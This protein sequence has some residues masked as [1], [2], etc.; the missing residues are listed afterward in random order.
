MAVLPPVAP[1]TGTTVTTRLGRDYYVTVGANAYSVHPEAIGRMITVTISLDRVVARCTDRI[2]ADHEGSGAQPDWSPIP[3][4]SRRRRS[5]GN[6]ICTDEQAP[7]TICR[8]TSKSP[9]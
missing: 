8:S 2:L 9:T 5:C 3:S 6:S 4:T 7:R 1:A